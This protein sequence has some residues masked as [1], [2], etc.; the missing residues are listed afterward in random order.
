MSETKEERKKRLHREKQARYRQRHPEKVRQIQRASY[1]KHSENRRKEAR[2]ASRLR[3]WTPERNETQNRWRAKNRDKVRAYN[4]EYKAKQR[5]T[6]LNF[7]LAELLRSRVSGALK[8]GSAIRDL[9]C[10]LDQLKEHIEAQFETGMTW[11]NHG[12]TG[13]H[14]DHVRPLA[15]FDLSDPDEFQKACHFS[16]LQ[17]LWA[18]ANLSKGSR[19]LTNN[20]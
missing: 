7:K 14:L 17:P 2:E 18:K 10:T 11:Q 15:S 3:E 9:G 13:W 8:G 16:N 5:L 12:R 1:A 20:R 19:W 6:N 4:R